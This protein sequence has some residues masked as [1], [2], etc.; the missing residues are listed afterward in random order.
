MTRFRSSRNRAMGLPR[1]LRRCL[2][3]SRR[4]A[5]GASSRSTATARI[6]RRPCLKAHSKRSL[7]AT[8]LLVRRTTEVIT[9]SARRRLIRGFSA[10]DG[11]GT[12]N[13]YDAL[14]ARARALGLSV[15]LTDPFYDIDVAAG[16]ESPCRRAAERARE[17]AENGAMVEGMEEGDAARATRRTSDEDHGVTQALRTRSNHIYGA[18]SVCPNSGRSGSPSLPC[19]PGHCRRRVSSSYS[20]IFLN[21]EISSPRHRNWSCVGCSVATSISVDAARGQTMTFIATSGMAACSGWATTL[22]LSFRT[23]LQF[24]ALHTDET[25]NS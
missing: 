20:R 23:I 18:F 4:L 15:S 9:L 6:C 7:R 11:L 10:G 2:H 25:R 19:Y 14:L 21:A 22:T 5:A 1:G 24:S 17:S 8:L 13:A 16:P 3:I 12:T